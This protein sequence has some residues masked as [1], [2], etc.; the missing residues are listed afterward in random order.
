MMGFILETGNFGHN[1]DYSY[2]K[3]H[4]YMVMKAI[5]LWKHLQ[6]FGRYFVIFPLDS[7]K[8]TWWRIGEGLSAVMKR[9]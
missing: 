3:K 5:S 7:I 1:R 8:V 9:K 4:S 6:D 2:Q